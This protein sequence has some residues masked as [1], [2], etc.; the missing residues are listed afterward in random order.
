MNVPVTKDKQ[1][2]NII[3]ISNSSFPLELAH[4]PQTLQKK[5][6]P[7][8]LVPQAC[9]ATLSNCG[10]AS[11]QWWEPT[12]RIQYTWPEPQQRT[13]RHGGGS[14]ATTVRVEMGPRAPE[15]LETHCAPQG[16]RLHLLQRLPFLQHLQDIPPNQKGHTNEFPGHVF[17]KNLWRCRCRWLLDCFLIC[18]FWHIFN[19][20]L[21]SITST[22]QFFYTRG[23]ICTYTEKFSHWKMIGRLFWPPRG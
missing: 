5:P 14:R 4:S 22:T 7:L 19:M 15:S 18:L 17:E 20:I 16:L 21:H 11:L 9:H 13:Q 6:A 12:K 3:F 2:K 1:K 8:V 23:T 10:A